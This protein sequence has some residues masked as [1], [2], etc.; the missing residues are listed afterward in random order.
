MA[1]E[2]WNVMVETEQSLHKYFNLCAVWVKKGQTK[3]VRFNIC[4]IILLC[5]LLK[6]LVSN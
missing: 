2:L 1:F 5:F 3:L 4:K 6:T